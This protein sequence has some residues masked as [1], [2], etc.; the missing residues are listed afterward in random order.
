MRILRPIFSFQ[1][2]I[3]F[4]LVAL[5]MAAMPI[6]PAEAGVKCPCTFTSAY[7]AAH[8]QAKRMGLPLPAFQ[9]C[10][11]NED[12][13]LLELIG[14]A[15]DCEAAIRVLGAGDSDECDGP[16]QCCSYTFICFEIG[17]ELFESNVLID[18]TEEEAEACE[19]VIRLHAWFNQIQCE[20]E[21]A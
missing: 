8:K 15:S 11:D 7:F 20:P 18:I 21:E 10:I 6:K 12:P 1:L 2:V 4:A 5:F 19:R 16:A 9:E 3:V 13:P 17:D 14:E